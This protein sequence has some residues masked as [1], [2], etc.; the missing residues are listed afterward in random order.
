MPIAFF[1]LGL[2]VSFM[3]GPLN[4]N[5]SPSF[6]PTMCFDSFPCS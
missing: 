1:M 4:S 5:V 2:Y 6:R 3:T